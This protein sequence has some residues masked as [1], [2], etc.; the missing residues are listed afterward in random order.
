M[1][2]GDT[3]GAADHFA[4]AAKKYHALQRALASSAPGQPPTVESVAALNEELPGAGPALRRH[5]SA[6]LQGYGSSQAP[7][8]GQAAP[9]PMTSR[10]TPPAAAATSQRESN[11]SSATP[12]TAPS[13]ASQ[14]SDRR[15]RE[16]QAVEIYS[17][18]ADKWL[19][20]TVVQI[21]ADMVKT[22]YLIDGHWCE[23][24][25]LRSSPSLRVKIGGASPRGAASGRP[26]TPPPGARPTPAPTRPASPQRSAVAAGAPGSTAASGYPATSGSPAKAATTPSEPEGRRQWTSSVTDDRGP[27]APS[28]ATEPEAPARRQ[29]TSPPSDDKEPEPKPAPAPAPQKKSH[30]DLL[31]GNELEFGTVIGSGG[32]GSVYRGMYRGQEVAIKK[33]HCVDGKITPMQLEEFRKEVTNLKA[34]RHPRLVS[35]IGAAYTDPSLCIVTEF[36]PNGSLYELLHQ[37][38]TALRFKQR[39]TIAVQITEGVEFLHGRQPLVVHRDLKSLNVVLD[40]QLNAKLCDFGL[41]QSMEKTHI[42][43]KESEG[44]SPRYMAPELF[45]SKGKITEK[46]DVWALGCLAVEVMTSRVPHEECSTIQQV[47]MKT[48]V[49]RKL[50]YLNW[51][52]AGDEL[53]ALAELCFVFS[54][55]QRL[56]TARFLEGLRALEAPS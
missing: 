56:D 2:R 7:P 50:P 13:S 46:V 20:G 47:M 24:V 39:H 35:F 10:S 12:A 3:R 41:T 15:F 9:A 43:R 49:D 26:K 1:E 42:T 16:G 18:S 45:D 34:L 28:R 14:D 38:K 33:L 4:L 44:G 51:E 25:L 23:K 32:F 52:G 37:K 8:A 17:K 19:E 29:W 55:E 36:M 40:H 22:K 27:A 30:S 5:L 21:S 53:R 31:D 48:L 11:A 6:L 54:V